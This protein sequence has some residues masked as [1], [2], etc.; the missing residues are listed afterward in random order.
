[1]N[2]L[3][4]E[5]ILITTAGF[6]RSLG[7]GLSGV[8]L[9]LHLHALGWGLRE[10]GFVVSAGLAGNAC[11][12]LLASLFADRLGRRKFL[13]LLSVLSI[14]GGFSLAGLDAFRSAPRL[15][16]AAAF[17]GLVNG[18]G[19]DRGPAYAL[20]QA[21]LPQTT[22]DERRTLLIAWYSLFMDGGLALGA[23][24]AGIPFFL[25]Q[26]MGFALLAS[27]QAAWLVYVALALVALLCYAALSSRVELPGQGARGAQLLPPPEDRRTICKLAALTGLDSLGGGFLNSA[28]LSFW[29]FTRFGI[30]EQWLGPLFA[31]ARVLN[32]VSHLVAAWLARRLGLLNTMVFTHIPSSLFLI[33]VPF[34]P[35][36]SWAVIL[37]LAREGLVEM[38]V[39]TR[40]SYILA[41]VR[42][43]ARSFAS[44]LTTVTRNISYATGPALAGWAMQA[45]AFSS[46]LYLGGGIKILYDLLLL[47]AFRHVKPPE[48]RGPSAKQ[49]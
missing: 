33:C 1:L 2:S 36:F 9:A 48:E 32:G 11:A 7:V 15:F 4:R 20:D 43:E 16:L 21:M 39:P 45:L 14:L 23:L 18:L 10:T 26:E 12:T 38:D 6:V 3:R 19:R 46:P 44:G 29:F 13:L 31:G 17:V 5:Q 37:F 35:S 40:Q 47:A 28:L 41:V 34:A 8:L 24:A 25:R 27:Y 42:P 30:G 22:S 49:P